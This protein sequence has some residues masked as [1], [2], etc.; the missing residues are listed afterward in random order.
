L[1]KDYKAGDWEDAVKELV[2]HG[3]VWAIVI[4]ADPQQKPS[5][6]GTLFAKK[7]LNGNIGMF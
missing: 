7:K 5:F 4:E 2:P 6:L 3:Y 1:G